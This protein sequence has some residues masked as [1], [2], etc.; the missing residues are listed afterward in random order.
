MSTSSACWRDAVAIIN[1]S[2]IWSRLF[3]YQQWL[4][5]CQ[6]RGSSREPA[7]AAT[8]CSRWRLHAASLLPH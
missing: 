6:T 5:F 4:F 3:S 8:S 2:N 7:A 1:D